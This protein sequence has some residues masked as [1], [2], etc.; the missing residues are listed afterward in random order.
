ML[1]TQVLCRG[2]R[3]FGTRAFR[4]R[5]CA[6]V[7]LVLVFIADRAIKHRVIL[8]ARDREKNFL[9]GLSLSP[10]RDLRLLI[11]DQVLLSLAFH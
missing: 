3:A 5:A 2:E 9:D 8:N 11:A 10:L 4:G 6:H 1:F 7:A